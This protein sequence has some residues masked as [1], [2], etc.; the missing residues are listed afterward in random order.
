MKN[1]P[2][3]SSIINFLLPAI[4]LYAIFFLVSFFDSGFFAFIYSFVLLVS[5]L[6]M[7]YV[8]NDIKPLSKTASENI[9]LFVILI[10]LSYV[11]ALLG[12]IT[13]WV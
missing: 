10:S 3:L 2:L 1:D 11:I 13:G 4:F 9:A 5:V 8:I 12:F 7:F 6:L